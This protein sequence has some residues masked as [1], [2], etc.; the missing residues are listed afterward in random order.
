M[1]THDHD[2][3]PE[4][5]RSPVTGRREDEG[6]AIA[7]L[8]LRAGRPDALDASAVTHLQ[9]AAGNANVAAL[10]GEESA[11]ERSP[12][13]DVVGSGGG[14]PLDASTRSFMESRLGHNFGDVRVHT[15]GK[16]ADSARAVNAHA[17]T[18]GHNVVFQRD[19]YAPETDT[20]R[21][22]LAHEL[23]HV[24]QQRSG[25]VDGTPAAGGIKI[26]DPSDRFEREAERTADQVMAAQPPDAAPRGPTTAPVVGV[27]RQEDDQLQGAFVQRQE[28]AEE[29]ELQ[30]FFVQRQEAA[31]EEEL[32]GCF[33]QREGEEEEMEEAPS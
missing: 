31:E 14:S 20:G 29:E 17:Y 33:I 15:D 25:P 5:I 22:M 26:S 30:G 12:V 10:L 27:Q 3:E 23:T 4:E 7:S 1:R 13:K 2:V 9:R 28:A 18:V 21:R 11:E 24:V 19:A 32:Q 16:A 6:E 8:A